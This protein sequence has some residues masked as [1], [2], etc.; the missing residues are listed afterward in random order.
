MDAN[1]L[2]TLLAQR[3]DPEAFRLLGTEI[4][5][6]REPTGAELAAA[7]EVVSNYE[8]LAAAYRPRVNVLTMRQARLQMLAMGV[9]SQVEA[10]V[11]QAGDAAQIE[12]EYAQTVERNHPLFLSIKGLLGFTDEQEDSFF[13]E[14]ALL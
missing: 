6:R 1:T 10:A 3:I 7:D 5:W 13:A 4:E 9:L 2:C 11:S 8:T 14:G 12:W